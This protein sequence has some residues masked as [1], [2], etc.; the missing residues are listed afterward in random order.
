MA[1]KQYGVTPEG[2]V[3]KRL[4]E[5]KAELEKELSDALGV[6]INNLANSVFGQIIG[7]F[8]AREA[9]L[10][11]V[12]EQVY[13]AMYP[14]TATGTSLTNSVA[15]S[16]V[17][18]LSAEKTRL[19]VTCY[20]L[21]NTT[22]PLGSRTRS[23]V[24]QSI[25]LSSVASG[26]ISMQNA[27]YIDLALLSVAAGERYW[28]AFGTQIYSYTAVAGDDKTSIL[29]TLAAQIDS[30][31]ID[32]AVSVS[33]EHLTI[34]RKDQSSGYIITSSGNIQI[35]EVGSPL[36]FECDVYGLIT[37][38]IGTITKIITQVAGWKRCANLV[39]AI[40]GREDETETALRQRY[41]TSVYQKGAAQV[42]SIRAALLELTNVTSAFVFENDTDE[43]DA[44]G[45]KPHSI[46]AIVMGGDNIE[47]AQTIFRKKAPVGTNGNI[48]VE[49]LD[50]QGVKHTI[51][52]NRPAVK[53]IWIK[54]VLEKNNDEE[55]PADTPNQVKQIILAE[56][57]KMLVG[58]DVILQRFLGPI[59][60]ATLG[61]G[62]ITIT[63]ATSETTPAPE[64]YSAANIPINTRELAGFAFD[65]IEVNP[66]D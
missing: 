33:N 38:A 62:L 24:D 56:G 59:Y 55:F 31:V 9:I 30:L 49:V 37:P 41:G 52:F 43:I 3:R 45:R 65:R 2:F 36:T 53:R 50:S 34:E 47:I 61:L 42:E 60:S 64:D 51:Y 8:S 19:I 44:D 10:W 26:K 6:P 13:Y 29:V 58:Q 5:I 21:N 20:G 14:H 25:T 4:P 48:A 7:V 11:E 27:S 54:A 66:I 39:A 35:V 16:G 22:I 1:S 15:F 28:I 63:A 23:D 32:G 12:A 40:V 17:K 46:E 57:Q 18:P